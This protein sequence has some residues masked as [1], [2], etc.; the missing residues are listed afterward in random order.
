MVVIYGL[1]FN[2]D[3]KK[4]AKFSKVEDIRRDLVEV[5]EMNS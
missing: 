3:L 5:R 2:V 4:G 1:I